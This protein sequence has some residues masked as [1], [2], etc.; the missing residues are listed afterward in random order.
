M[1]EVHHEPHIATGEAV[2]LPDAQSFLVLFSLHKQM[3]LLGA[4]ASCE[5]YLGFASAD[6]AWRSESC[7]M[8]LSMLKTYH[9]VTGGC[10]TLASSPRVVAAD[11]APGCGRGTWEL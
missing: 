9:A 11:E 3:R 8:V 7:D 1:R 6:Y 2:L 4:V 10:S 5:V